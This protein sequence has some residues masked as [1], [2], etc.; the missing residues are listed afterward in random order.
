MSESSSYKKKYTILQA[1]SSVYEVWR[2]TLKLTEE[3]SPTPESDSEREQI[4][5]LFTSSLRL[6]HFR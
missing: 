2:L 1:I 4:I 3:K 6:I 5:D